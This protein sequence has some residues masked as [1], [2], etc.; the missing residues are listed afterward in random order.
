MATMTAGAR[1]RPSRLITFR[2]MGGKFS[3]LAWLLPLL[4]K[5]GH[6]IEACGGSGT[7]LLNREPSKFETFNDLNG[8]VVNFF[9]ILRDYPDRLVHALSLTPW[10][11]GEFCSCIASPP[12]GRGGVQ[13]RVERARRFYVRCEMGFLAKENP[14]PGNWSKKMTAEDSNYVSGFRGKISRLEFAAERFLNVQVENR[15]ALYVIEKYDSEDA[16]FYVDPPYL[17]KTRTAGRCYTYEMDEEGHRALAA[18][19]NRCRGK[20]A[21]SAYPH[22]MLAGLYPAPKWREHRERVKAVHGG[23]SRQEALYTNY[24]PCAGRRGLFDAAWRDD[25]P[26]GA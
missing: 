1:E 17:M 9:E 24:D 16:L 22:G 26:D 3:H 25:G 10:A 7:V 20:V 18:A 23:A 11:R 12:A 5:C 13:E 4:P 8:D 19:L 2:W 21:L 6:Y 14:T 15:D